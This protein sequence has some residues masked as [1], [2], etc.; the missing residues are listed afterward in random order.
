M[1]DFI[2]WFWYFVVSLGFYAFGQS[3]EKKYQE[4]GFIVLTI[5]NIIFI[6]YVICKNIPR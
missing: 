1:R 2:I 3:D 4:T 5:T 6:C